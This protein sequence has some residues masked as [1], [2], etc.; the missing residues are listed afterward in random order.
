MPKHVT[1]SGHATKEVKRITGLKSN[2]LS[3]NHMRGKHTV[4]N[5]TGKVD[6]GWQEETVE[7]RVTVREGV[8]RVVWMADARIWGK[9]V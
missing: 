2:P 3:S 4:Y 8:Y 5:H 9:E 7:K 1:K 6:L